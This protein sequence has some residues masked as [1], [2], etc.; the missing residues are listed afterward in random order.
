LDTINWKS[1]A[2]RIENLKSVG[3]NLAVVSIKDATDPLKTWLLRY[4]QKCKNTFTLIKLLSV[5]FYINLNGGL[6]SLK[7]CETAS[8]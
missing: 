2:F 1:E 5:I 4:L 6:H 8:L 3:N 7:T